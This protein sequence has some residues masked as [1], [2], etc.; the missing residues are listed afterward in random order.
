MK[1]F[2]WI[3]LFATILSLSEGSSPPTGLIL[4]V[5]MADGSMKRI[6]V[7]PGA[8]PSLKDVL[9]PLFADQDEP[10]KD[11]PTVKIG[12]SV[13]EDDSQT[14]SSLGLRQGSLIQL[15]L[16]KK[17]GQEKQH[18]PSFSTSEKKAADRWDPFPEIAK[19]HETAVRKTKTRRSTQS[20]MSFG[21]LADLQSS[22]HVVEPQPEG[23]LK[24]VYMCA[25]SA[26]RFQENC[27]KKKLN[28]FETRVGLLL[29]TVQRERVDLKPKAR[30]S[31]SSQT[32]SEQYCEIVKVHAVWEPP[33]Q[34]S[35]TQKYDPSPLHDL[36]KDPELQ[37]VFRL[38]E[39]LGLRVC[40]W[41][42][43]YNDNRH[44]DEDS[45][46]VYGPDAKTGALLQ[47]ANMQKQGRTDGT[48]FATLSMDATTGATEAFQLS[49]VCV[50]M[51]AEDLWEVPKKAG[52]TPRFVNTKH[53][54]IVDGKETKE[55]DSVLCLVNTAMLSHE[56]SFAGNFNGV[57]KNG[58]IT[59]KAK[60]AILSAI[61][62]KDDARLLDIL[63]NFNLLLAL[64]QTI[65]KEDMEKLCEK[66]RKYA[67]GQRRGTELDDK[68]KLLLRSMLDH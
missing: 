61:D 42:F 30:T 38:A 40:G 34:Q 29:G 25:T 6:Q 23:P 37:R 8:D 50:Q 15:V 48:R 56:G 33:T 17:K 54:V 36:K 7:K 19:D 53:A 44:K 9:E 32:E 52:T 55:L 18:K 35:T 49:D 39:L 12:T 1:I 3:F 57:K 62:A 63:T 67:R 5:R 2:N 59:T 4:R 16:P 43:S 31:L 20:G 26:A 51:I 45:L 11:K 46:P 60:K 41:I 28:E 27:F 64:D 21:H 14:I 22:L 47:I 10:V 66:V 65:S 24:R 68:M 58:G 13:V